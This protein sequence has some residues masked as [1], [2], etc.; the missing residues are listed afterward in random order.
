ML[1]TWC[2]SAVNR[3]FLSRSAA[4]RTRSS[5]LS[6]PSRCCARGAFCWF[7]FPLA[8][9]LPSIPSAADPP[10][11]FGDFVGTTGLSDCP[12]PFIVDVRP[13]TSRRGPLVHH[14]RA[15][16]GSPGSLFFFKQKTA[17]DLPK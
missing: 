10:A 2:S 9:P 8:R 17:Y 5:A 15:D 14:Q 4:W 11:L 13:W 3:T 12:W 16:R 6:A 7:G 1:Y